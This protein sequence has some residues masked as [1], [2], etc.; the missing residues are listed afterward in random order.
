M[1]Q[2]IDC[3]MLTSLGHKDESLTGERKAKD[4]DIL[5][6]FPQLLLS[7]AIFTA[8]LVVFVSCLRWWLLLAIVPFVKVLDH[9]V[10]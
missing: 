2:R 1:E 7:Y 4:S 9:F 6:I 3:G 10:L 5:V 8:K